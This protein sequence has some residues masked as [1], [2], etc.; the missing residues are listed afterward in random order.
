[1]NN[2]KCDITVVLDRS[3]SMMVIMAETIGGFNAF[4]SDQQKAPGEAIITLNLF[5]HEFLPT[6]RGEE[7]KNA[8][9]LTIETYVPRGMTALL[10]AIGRSVIE[11]GQRLEK[12]AE[13]DRPGK[14]VLMI[15]TDGQENAS[16]EFTYPKIKA[17]LK[18]Q[19]EKYAWQVTFLGANIDAEYVGRNLGTQTVN[20]MSY[21]HDAVGA[22]SMFSSSSDNLKAYRS[23]SAKDL[24]YSL[25]NKLDAMAGVKKE[26]KKKDLK[27]KTPGDPQSP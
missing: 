22:S 17:M 20:S 27:V 26:P 19:Q 2:S 9:P 16:K 13:A 7:I 11:T 23:G 3:G 14:V 25:Q 10:D 21:G 5:D 1:M 4:L 6:I 18:E 8:K 12:M 24:G 15:I